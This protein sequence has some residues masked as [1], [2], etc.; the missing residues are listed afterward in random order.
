MAGPNPNGTALVCQACAKWPALPSLTLARKLYAAHPLTWNTLEACRMAITRRRGRHTGGK[1]R[2]WPLVKHIIP[3]TAPRTQAK[4]AL[5]KS[6]ARPFQPYRV[7]LGRTTQRAAVLG[8]IHLP[9]HDRPALQAAIA[10]A[11]AWLR[12]DDL[13]FLNG[14][15]LDFHAVSRFEKNPH[16]RNLKG[17]IDTC[18]AFLDHLH[19]QMPK[20]RILWKDGNHDERLDKFVRL[21]APELYDLKEIRLAEL[22]SLEHRGIEYVTGKRPVYL[23]KLPV[24]HGHEW[25]TPVLGPVNAARG[26]F[27]RA[28]ASAMVN[29]HHQTSEHTEPDVNGGIITTWSNGCLCDLHPEYAVYNKWNHG[30]ARVEFTADSFQVSNHRIHAGKLLN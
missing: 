11:R 22:L 2:R 30:I 1:S 8:D 16:A 6:D 28:K 4:Y 17:E 12:P 26:L 3:S 9:Y 20:V 13:L 25:P 21:K 5:P 27:L 19:E 18:R 10:S 14:D 23:G 24:L 7:P 15:T 29:H